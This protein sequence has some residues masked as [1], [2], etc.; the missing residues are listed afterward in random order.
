M[1]GLLWQLLLSWELLIFLCPP[2][3][4]IPAH[5]YTNSLLNAPQCETPQCDFSY[6]GGGKTLPM[7]MVETSLGIVQVVFFCRLKDAYE[8][9]Q[10]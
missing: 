9:Q 10:V 1:A 5:W 3:P 4:Y 8:V 6:V 7:P 2:S